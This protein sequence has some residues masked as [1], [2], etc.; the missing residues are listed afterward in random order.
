M[1]QTC[2]K[3]IEISELDQTCPKWIKLVQIGSNLFILD[4]TCLNWINY[5]L[6][7][8]NLWGQLEVVPK[9]FNQY[10]SFQVYDRDAKVCQSYLINLGNFRL[11]SPKK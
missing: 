8:S 10:L 7:G 4:Q 11:V 2:P 1:D 3:W 9:N 6:I 5:V